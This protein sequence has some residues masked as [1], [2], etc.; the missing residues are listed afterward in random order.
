MKRVVVFGAGLVVRAHVRYLLDHGFAVTVASR[1]VSKAEAILDGHPNGTPLAFDIARDA[2]RLGPIIAD[3]DLAVSLLPWQYHPKVARACLDRGRHMVTT[4]YVKDE[5]A[6][7]DAEARA[8]GIVLLNELGVDPGI[9]HMTAMK[10]IHRV[11]AEGG[12]ITTFQS[13]CGGL[14]APEANDNPL[15]YKFSWSP[16]GVL[17]AGLNN[18]RYKRYGKVVEVP[19]RELFD[20]IRKVDVVIEGVPTELEG[21]PN[22]DSM[23]YTETY[24]IDPR[25]VM[26]RG[27]LRNPGWCP[28]MKQVARL[29][30]LGT[31]ELT[32]LEGRTFAD[33]TARLVGAPGTASLRGNVAAHLGVDASG[34]EIATME[35][36][37]L[38][39]PDPLPGPTAPVDI[40]TARML[41]K[42]SY[43]KNERDM[44][45]LQHT[46]M[47]EYPDRREHITSTMVDFGIPG[48]DSS[49]NRTV[50]LPA[51]VGVRLILEGRFTR[52]GVIVPVMPE[53]YEPALAELERLGIHFTEEVRTAPPV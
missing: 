22:R 26:F 51:A 49:M 8:K 10:V 44:L 39:G 34:P 1:T 41:E 28:T 14:P 33:L 19:G 46:F 16:R 9:D 52:P 42:M 23:P 6:A 21:Y 30:W 11:Q 38:L 31:E 18:A 36:L 40:L 45:V 2:D 32:G 29:G 37:G 53:L 25:D 17:L 4:S 48:G 13:Y 7:L 15:G 35:W 20:H 24:G 12:E 3:H 43:G 50:G 27:T 47:A 5:M